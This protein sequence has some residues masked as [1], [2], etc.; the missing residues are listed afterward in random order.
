MSPL[1]VRAWP[2]SAD[3]RDSHFSITG[4]A[5]GMVPANK[6]RLTTTDALPPFDDLNDGVLITAIGV[7]PDNVTYEDAPSE[8]VL[9]KLG[10]PEP[11]GGP[12]TF[13]IEYTLN[14]VRPGEFLYVGFIR[15]T[16]PDGIAVFEVQLIT[17]DPG[18][19]KV[20]NPVVCTPRNYLATS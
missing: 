14:A 3:P 1:T 10:F 2:D 6:Y 7:G 15:Q 9:H 8:N 16:Y 20:P 4:Y 12:P 13:T 5:F 17:A 19:N 11:I 18:P